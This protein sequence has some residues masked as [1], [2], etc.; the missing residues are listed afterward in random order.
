MK[1]VLIA[2]SLGLAASPAAARSEIVTLS[3]E[4]DRADLDAPTRLISRIVNALDVVA[5][6]DL[7]DA[8][9]RWQLGMRDLA[10]AMTDR[11]SMLGAA[12]GGAEI[13]IPSLAVLTNEPV[14]G[15]MAPESSGFGWRDDPFHH[16]A[17]YHSGTDFRAPSGTPV[18]AAGAGIVV[19]CGRRGGY[20]N[21]IEVNHG[22]GVITRYAHL[23]KLE[24]KRNAV[25]VGGQRI[26]QIGST[27]RATGPHLHF[28]VRLDG[29]AVDPGTAMA[30]AELERWAP[31]AGRLAAFALSPEL[32][33]YEQSHLDP[34]R[35]RADAANK[36]EERPERAGRTKRVR[37]VS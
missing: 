31:A 30:I 28:E 4:Y 2:L 7:V 37:P 17:K 27:G 13:V 12:L 22:G 20:G 18:M 5:P 24:T 11:I 14:A 23:R 36:S 6:S 26:G 10:R 8:M 1:V 15:S 32:Q 33:E 3:P 29:R 34:P 35:E 9:V 21:V 16:R 25:I 19:F